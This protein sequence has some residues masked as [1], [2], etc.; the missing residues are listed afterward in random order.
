MTFLILHVSG[1]F[2]MMTITAGLLDDL[3]D[4][5]KMAAKSGSPVF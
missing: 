3:V 4:I 5:F 2:C 1:T